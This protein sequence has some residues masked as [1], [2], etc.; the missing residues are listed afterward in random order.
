MSA[1]ET[2][3]TT[4]PA[5]TTPAGTTLDATPHAVP[6]VVDPRYTGPAGSGHGGVTAGYAAALVDPRRAVVR[7]H[8]AIPLGTPLVP[9]SRADGA[10]VL[11]AGPVPVATARRGGPWDVPPFEPAPPALVRAAE[12]HWLDARAGVHP[13]P[14][15]F[16][17]G[18]DRVDGLGLRPGPV[19]GRGVHATRWVPPGEGEVPSWLLWAALDCAS[20]GPVLGA[21]ARG[22]PLTGEL[23][24]EQRLPVAAGRRHTLYARTARR[25]GRRVVTEAAL[26][27]DRGLHAAVAVVTWFVTGSEVPS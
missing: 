7:L 8:A 24:V 10:V 11:H 5:G 27:D 20:A 15:C 14:R 18:P 26:L 21:A 19:R 9:R 13:H 2:L 17:C 3:G 4:T 25:R 22:G 16:G 12:R 6:V 23:A 1:V